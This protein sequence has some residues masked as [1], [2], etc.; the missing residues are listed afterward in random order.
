MA[1]KMFSK[2]KEILG[3]EEYNDEYDE[4]DEVD[5]EKETEVEETIEPVI[6]KKNMGQSNKVVNIHTAIAAKVIIIKATTYEDAP[7]VCDALRNRKIVVVNT[8]GLEIKIAQRL[9]DFMSGAC[10]ALSGDLQE[11]DRGVY[12][13]SPSNVEVSNELKSELSTK[14]L[15][16]W[17]K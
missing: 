15:F 10:Y 9:L 17:N 13:L 12:L 5:E 3:F 4:V 8:T 11:I 2:V 14:G 16:N 1:P 7:N 6:S